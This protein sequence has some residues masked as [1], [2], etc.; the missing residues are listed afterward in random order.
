MKLRIGIVVAAGLLLAGGA[1]AEEAPHEVRQIAPD[2]FQPNLRDDAEVRP[3]AAAAAAP[4]KE[5]PLGS[6]DKASRGWLNCLRATADLSAILVGAAENQAVASLERRKN[7]S[8][9]LQRV[10]AKALADADAKWAELRELECS[11]LALL[12]VG[13]GAPLYEAQLICRI[14]HNM[15]RIDQLTTRYG[16]GAS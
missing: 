2:R 8:A 9:S 16:A 6:C 1:I 5:H 15:E 12:E 4:T 13:P 11:Q 3:A 14:N 7:A 10:L